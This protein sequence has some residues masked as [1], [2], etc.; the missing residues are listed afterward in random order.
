EALEQCADLL[1][2]F[3][4]HASAAGLSLAT[5]HVPELRRRLSAT[6][7]DML[8]GNMP[9]R[10]YR[11]DAVAEHDELSLHAVDELARL[12]PFGHANPQPV[13]LIPRVRPAYAQASRDGRHL[14]FKVVDSRGR[15]H[16][17]VLFGGGE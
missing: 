6:V 2:R 16:R 13:L 17:A 15:R 14:L 5:E 7:L 12:E 8:G 4:G 9:E 10:E 1:E 3:G 11:I